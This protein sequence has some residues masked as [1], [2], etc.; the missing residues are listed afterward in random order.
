M[1]S[2]SRKKS[3]A[4]K[5]IILLSVIVVAIVFAYKGIVQSKEKGFDIAASNFLGKPGK[6][7]PKE[8]DEA[9]HTEGFWTNNKF[10]W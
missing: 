2:K 5:Q 6:R 3:S 4:F 10:K 7:T 8:L 1:K 9:G